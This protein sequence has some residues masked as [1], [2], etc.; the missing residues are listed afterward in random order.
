MSVEPHFWSILMS[1]G[2]LG[3]G[4]GGLWGPKL[5]P[6]VAQEAPK[7]RSKIRYGYSMSIL[8]KKLKKPCIY[9][10]LEHST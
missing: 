2:G 9:K 3:V 4:L 10:G 6:K 7:M 8:V 5:E 1:F